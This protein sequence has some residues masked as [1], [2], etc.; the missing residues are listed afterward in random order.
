MIKSITLQKVGVKPR[1][2][3]D[4]LAHQNIAFDPL[5]LKNKELKQVTSFLFQLHSDKK[6]AFLDHCYSR[7][8]LMIL[9]KLLTWN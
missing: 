9:Q 1:W 5:L 6:A 4:G 7:Y 2:L 3:M 8:T